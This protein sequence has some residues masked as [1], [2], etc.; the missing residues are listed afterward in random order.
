MRF[1][2]RLITHFEWLLPL[3]ALAV[4][5]MGVA[6]VYSATHTP[7]T[8]GLTPLALRQLTWLA[9]GCIA[10]ILVLLFDYRRLERSGGIVYVL[11]LL[12]VFAVPIITL[13]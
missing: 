8:Q 3:L 1:D 2:R 7:T 11:V 10:M 4:S 6:T 12:A 13:S 5:A 9:G